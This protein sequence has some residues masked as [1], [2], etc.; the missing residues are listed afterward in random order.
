MIAT[1]IRRPPLSIAFMTTRRRFRSATLATPTPAVI[2]RRALP[3]AAMASAVAFGMFRT[4]VSAQSA[5]APA[6][7]TEQRTR[8]APGVLTVI[9]PS[10]M[11]EETYDGPLVLEEFLS[12]HPAIVWDAPARGRRAARTPA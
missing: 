1:P 5:T 11:P 2:A 3:V 6:P 4:T 7:S 9:P 12:A 8:F 10:P